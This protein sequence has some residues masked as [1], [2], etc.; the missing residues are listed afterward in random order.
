MVLFLFYHFKAYFDGEISTLC[1]S[2]NTQLNILDCEYKKPKI[3]L[4]VYNIFIL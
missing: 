2:R 1:E 4:K 3:E